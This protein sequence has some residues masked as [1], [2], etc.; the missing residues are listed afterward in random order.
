LAAKDRYG[1]GFGLWLLGLVLCI[2]VVVQAFI[3]VAPWPFAM[4]LDRA[5]AEWPGQVDPSWRA[6]VRDH[7]RPR[8]WPLGTVADNPAGFA[9]WATAL[10]AGGAGVWYCFR[11]LK[12]LTDGPAEPGAAADPRRQSGSGG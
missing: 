1:W 2:W 8:E 12:R 5:E 11:R 10:V 4:P 7:G 3:R 9:G 6:V